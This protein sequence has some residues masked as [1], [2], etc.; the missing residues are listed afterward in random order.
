MRGALERRASRPGLAQAALLEDAATGA[1]VKGSEP[2]RAAQRVAFNGSPPARLVEDG[3]VRVAADSGNAERAESWLQ[4]CSD[5]NDAGFPACFACFHDHECPAGA[6]CAINR[7]TGRQECV[8]ADCARD[9][10]CLGGW[11]CVAVGRDR[12]IR[13][14]V[15]HGMRVA[16]ETCAYDPSSTAY[17]C[18]EG[19]VCLGGTC[20]LPCPTRVCAAGA[21]CVDS[22]DGPACRIRP[23]SCETTGC[24][25]GQRCERLGGLESA[26][27]AKVTGENCFAHPC[28][29]GQAC[30]A[31]AAA[32]QIVLWCA[33]TC[34]P[35]KPACP[36]G[37][38]CGRSPNDPAK[39]E[40]YLSCN[41]ENPSC[42]RDQACTLMS[43]NGHAW[44]CMPTVREK[45]KP[46]QSDP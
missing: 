30:E 39:S 17:G 9:E 5:T 35:L 22:P 37:Q 20:A 7:K 25:A 15:E 31:Q 32:D 19:L 46:G 27:F 41:S 12:R 16:G 18:T 42:P 1:F 8:T 4:G 10:D 36:S 28:P 11:S 14:C 21:T 43:E 2:E 44:G 13:R 33:T 23:P 26:C 38:S 34:D 40:C 45:P 6:S 24:D 3:A 29:M